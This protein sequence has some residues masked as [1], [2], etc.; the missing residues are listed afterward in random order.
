MPDHLDAAIV[1]TG[2]ALFGVSAMAPLDWL[3]VVLVIT[4]LGI[5]AAAR[6]L[7]VGLPAGPQPPVPCSECGRWV[8]PGQRVCRF[9]GTNIV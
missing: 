8:R 4:L 1:A 6:V 5:V 2:V 9:C 3:P 7:L